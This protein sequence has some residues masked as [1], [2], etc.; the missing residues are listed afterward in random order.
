MRTTIK[1]AEK[2]KA[3]DCVIVNGETVNIVSVKLSKKTGKIYITFLNG[4]IKQKIFTSPKK[5]L[6]F[7]RL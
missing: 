3:N 1:P 4:E 6:A 2:A 7:V 5:L